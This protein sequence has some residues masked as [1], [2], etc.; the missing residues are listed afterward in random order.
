M[1]KN[2]QSAM[3]E[4][5]SMDFALAALAVTE[6]VGIDCDNHCCTKH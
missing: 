2:A 3:L 5:M 4:L 6:P 1:G